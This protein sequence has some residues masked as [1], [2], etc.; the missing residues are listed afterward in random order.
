MR[1]NW[2]KASENIS[3]ALFK[4]AEL[5]VKNLSGYCTPNDLQMPL[6]YS[7]KAQRG[8]PFVPYLLNIQDCVF[9]LSHAALACERLAETWQTTANIC[10]FQLLNIQ[11][12]L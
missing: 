9:S 4:N 7:L 11:N 6:S 10:W 8:A 3:T 5:G 2:S 12:L 1:Q